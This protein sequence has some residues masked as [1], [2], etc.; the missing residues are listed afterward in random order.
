M[1]ENCKKTGIEV[2]GF[3]HFLHLKPNDNKGIDTLDEQ[4][5]DYF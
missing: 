3:I 4:M 2:R 5:K 1:K